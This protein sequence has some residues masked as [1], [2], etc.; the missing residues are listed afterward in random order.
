ML[1]IKLLHMKPVIGEAISLN[2]IYFEIIFFCT[3]KRY[4]EEP[5]NSIYAVFALLIISRLCSTTP[6]K[7]FSNFNNFHFAKRRCHLKASYV[8]FQYAFAT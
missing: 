2:I 8:E 4:S 3:L 6:L 1:T 7:F 5:F